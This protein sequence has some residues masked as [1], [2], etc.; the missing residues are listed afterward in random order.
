MYSVPTHPVPPPRATTPCPVPG[1]MPVRIPRRVSSMSPGGP[2]AHRPPRSAAGNITPRGIRPRATPPTTPPVGEHMYPIR[3][4]GPYWPLCRVGPPFW[5]DVPPR[6]LASITGQMGAKWC[7]RGGGYRGT[8]AAPWGGYSEP[9]ASVMV[10]R[11]GGSRAPRDAP[12]RD[13]R[14]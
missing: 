3:R 6:P 4:I 11:G 8:P 14:A 1:A 9:A 7:H 10:P 2:F 5:H 12:P 13:A